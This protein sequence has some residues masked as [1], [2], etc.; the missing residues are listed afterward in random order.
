MTF[1]VG[2]KVKHKI[3]GEGVVSKIEGKGTKA[4]VTIQYA[5]DKKITYGESYDCFVVELKDEL[6]KN[7]NSDCVVRIRN[8]LG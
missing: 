6:A 4:M 8:A 3:F 7:W 5:N 2:K 1:Y